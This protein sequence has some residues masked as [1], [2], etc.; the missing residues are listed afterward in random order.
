VN[1]WGI[2]LLGSC[3]LLSSGFIL[4]L[5][6]HSLISGNKDLTL[7][8]FFFTVLMGAF[9]LFLQMT[10]YYYGSFTIADSVFGSVFYLGTG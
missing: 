4:T 1:P 6:H 9:F 2:P 5:G 10:E 3:I 8:S 7:V